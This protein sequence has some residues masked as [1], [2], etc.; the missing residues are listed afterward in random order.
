MLP[1]NANQLHHVIVIWLLLVCTL[2]GLTLLYSLHITNYPHVL[3]VLLCSYLSLT[4]HSKLCFL[5][6]KHYNNSLEWIRIIIMA[7][8][9]I[10]NLYRETIWALKTI[11]IKK[12][13]HIDTLG[14][15]F[16]LAILSYNS[17]RGHKLLPI[18]LCIRHNKLV[19]DWQKGLL[20][21]NRHL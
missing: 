5:L 6:D 21:A 2:S 18:L 20:T 11:N 17:Q 10:T 9:C 13:N 16:E 3:C 1:N 12:K 19:Q 7:Y 14:P 15:S 4:K 8:K